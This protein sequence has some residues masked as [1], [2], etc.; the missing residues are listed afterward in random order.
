MAA[1]CPSVA[2]VFVFLF[3][4]VFFLVWFFSK[5]DI[6]P[7]VVLVARAS[8]RVVRSWLLPA[9]KGII[10]QSGGVGAVGVRQ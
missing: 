3:L 4:F 10:Q 2:F 9:G 6:G 1:S 5:A 8:V 7:L